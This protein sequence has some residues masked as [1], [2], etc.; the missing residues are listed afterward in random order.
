MA[1]SVVL[2]RVVPDALV[3]VQAAI[4]ALPVGLALTG[5]GV[6]AVDTGGAM[7]TKVAR[8]VINVLF[9]VVPFKS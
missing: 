4:P 9:T 8:T 7:L 5:V 2:A 1:G 3:N 6:D